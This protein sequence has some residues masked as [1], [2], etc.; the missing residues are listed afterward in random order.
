MKSPVCA[1]R[2]ASVLFGVVGVVH[3]VRILAGVTIL[4]SGYP[5]GRRWSAAA[6]VVLATLCIW[7]WTVA[8]AVAKQQTPAAPTPTA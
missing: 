6:V 1:L 4:V 3:V 2:L 5:I 7:F 8:S